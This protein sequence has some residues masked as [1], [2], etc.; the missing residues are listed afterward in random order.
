MLIHHWTDTAGVARTTEY[1]P[2]THILHGISGLNGRFVSIDAVPIVQPTQ[3]EI[4]AKAQAEL[5]DSIQRHLDSTA[6]TRNY[7]G[8]LSLCTYVTSTDPLFAAEGQAGVV[9]RDACWRKGYE[10]MAAVLAGNRPI[11]TES[12]LLAEMPAIGW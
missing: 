9:W 3:A 12:E 1:D 8:I 4:F 2:T 6:Q 10:I 5:T 7:D 11:P